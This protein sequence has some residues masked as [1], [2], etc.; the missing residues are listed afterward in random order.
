MLG[1]H[2]TRL[3]SL[4]RNRFESSPIRSPLML[5]DLYSLLLFVNQSPDSLGPIPMG[6]ETSLRLR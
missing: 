1:D 6:S 5:V 2:L 4:S 3:E